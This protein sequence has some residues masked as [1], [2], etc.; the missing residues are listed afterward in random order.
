MFLWY[1]RYYETVAGGSGAGPTWNGQSG[2]HVHMTNTRLTD[3]EILER[4]YPVY[5]KSF[6]LARGS[7]GRGKYSGGNGV[8]RETVFRKPLKLSVLT[9]RRALRPYGLRGGEAGSRGLNLLRRNDGRLINL[10]GKCSVDVDTGDVFIL[11]TPGGG[12]WGPAEK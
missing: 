11:Q 3:A 7:G 2:V 12:G 9:D 8:I 6:S 1:F 5:L 10:G 4:R